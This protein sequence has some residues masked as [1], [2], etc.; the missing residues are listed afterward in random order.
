MAKVS[1]PSSPERAELQPKKSMRLEIGE[2]VREI[3]NS[4]NLEMARETK[5]RAIEKYQ[6]R[7]PEFAKWL[8]ENIEEGFTIFHFPKE[9]WRRIRASNGI[10]RVNREIKRR[11]RVAVLFPNKDSALRL[12]TGVMMEI[13]EEWITGRQYLD[14]SPL[15]EQRSKTE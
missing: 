3:F 4:P 12:V 14:M 11:T 8:E 15:F 1:I 2:T 10:E 9:H 6:K 5:R 13:H 7:A